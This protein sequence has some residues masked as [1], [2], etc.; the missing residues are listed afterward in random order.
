MKIQYTEVLIAVESL[1]VCS[2]NKAKGLN[3]AGFFFC[4]L[5][6]L[7]SF[8]MVKRSNKIDIAFYPEFACL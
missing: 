5:F 2:A 7:H 3:A 4:P 8:Q 6:V 1:F